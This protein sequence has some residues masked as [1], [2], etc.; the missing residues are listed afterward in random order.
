MAGAVRMMTFSSGGI[1]E[2]ARY[3]LDRPLPPGAYDPLDAGDAIA[4]PSRRRGRDEMEAI[5]DDVGDGGDD[6]GD[7]GGGHNH[8]SDPVFV[9]VPCADEYEIMSELKKPGKR[10]NCFACRYVGQD[11][12]AKIP[13]QRLASVLTTMANGIGESWPPALAVVVAKQYE[14]WRVII[15]AT[16]G[17]RDPLPVWNAASVL[18]HW[19]SH[20]C[21]PEIQQWL[22]LMAIQYT[23]RTIRQTSL[24]K[25][26]IQTKKR[27]HD[28]DQWAIWQ[29]AVRL[30]YTVSAKEPRKLSYFKEGAMI[31][32]KSMA[33]G[34]I[35]RTD[36]PV[37]N[38]FA[39]GKRHRV[40]E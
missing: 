1:S 33:N 14:S 8:N 40:A 4:A 38:F 25:M 18:D 34:G 11:R 16:R 17:D 19:Y 7:G 12:G 21:D 20:T 30:W 5:D 9:P 27:R 6:D 35:S 36:R 37:Y 23:I 15:N 26:N 24:E 32:R 28:K 2:G 10:Y 31:N 13:D 29:S 3:L 22:H 39:K